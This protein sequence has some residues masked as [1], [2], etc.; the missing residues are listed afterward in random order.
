[1]FNPELL[2]SVDAYIPETYIFDVKQKIDMYKR[3]QSL[4]SQEE[5]DDLEEEL[6]DR[7]GDYPNEV[8]ELF[9]VTS[10]KI[11]AKR[12]LVEQIKKSKSRIEC[13]VESERSKQND[14]SKLFELIK[15]YGRNVQIDMTNDKLKITYKFSKESRKER[16]RLV[17]KC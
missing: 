2:L 11:L 13:L 12:E 1:P 15:K 10:L 5:M 9:S 14:R 3:F 16:Y 17:S 8:D 7:F 6:V 4:E